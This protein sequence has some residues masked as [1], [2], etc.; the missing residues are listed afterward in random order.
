MREYRTEAIEEARGAAND[1]LKEIVENV[2]A[3]EG[4]IRETSIDDYASD[5]YVSDKS[6]DLK[7]AADLLDD[8]REYEETDSGLWEGQEDPREA[9]KVMAAF[10]YR[11]AVNSLFEDLMTHI[12]ETVE[13]AVGT[14]LFF[15]FDEW[16]KSKG[17]AEGGTLDWRPGISDEEKEDQEEALQ[18]EHENETKETVKKVVIEAIEGW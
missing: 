9:V 7:D 16:V 8:L 10:T 5:G 17:K 13:T 11:N 6:L 12:N 2:I 18:E 14:T 4:E 15:D 3:A 1:F